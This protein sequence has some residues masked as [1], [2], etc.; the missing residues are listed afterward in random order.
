MTSYD[1]IGQY[2]S[3]FKQTDYYDGGKRASSAQQG[4]LGQGATPSLTRRKHA[5]AR[6]RK[7]A[8]VPR[9]ITAVERTTQSIAIGAYVR[10]A[11]RFLT[12]LLTISNRTA[13]TS[14]I[15][16][17]ASPTRRQKHAL[18]RAA[19]ATAYTAPRIESKQDVRSRLPGHSK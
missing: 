10:I 3:N 14:Y 1:S 2:H 4:L 8:K 16:K 6:S 19:T 9:A 17:N 7:E 18:A 12:S 15:D 5:H 11:S 13:Q